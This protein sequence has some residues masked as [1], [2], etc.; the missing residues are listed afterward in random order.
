VADAENSNGSGCD[1]LD[2]S[3]WIG[4][5]TMDVIGLAGF[6]Y[7]FNSLAVPDNEL[8][9]AFHDLFSTNGAMSIMS[10]LQFVIPATRFIP[11][12]RMRTQKRSLA[13]QQ[14]IG[15]ALIQKK[16]EA[17]LSGNVEKEGKDLLSLIVRANMDPDL[18]A[19][20][21]MSDNEVLGQIT[22]FFLAGKWQR[23]SRKP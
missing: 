7:E 8:A 9:N 3:Y 15:N 18:K 20:Q 14:K 2:V 23:G 17:V 5:C 1:Y 4:K 13:I 19:S 10:I 22:T 16:K 11:T 6:D 12:R 21:R